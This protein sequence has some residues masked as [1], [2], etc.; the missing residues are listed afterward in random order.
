MTITEQLAY[1]RG[2]AVAFNKLGMDEEHHDLIKRMQEAVT[3]EEHG[4]EEYGDTAEEAARLGLDDI[5]ALARSHQADEERHRKENRDALD[6]LYT[7]E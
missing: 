3:D 1:A 6:T 7:R 5:E 4:K 2:V